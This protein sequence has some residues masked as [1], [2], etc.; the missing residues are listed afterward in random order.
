MLSS[1]L[2]LQDVLIVSLNT[3]EFELKK[4]PSLATLILGP[5]LQEADSSDCAGLCL[6]VLG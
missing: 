4:I 6:R 3:M 5:K 2:T 1:L